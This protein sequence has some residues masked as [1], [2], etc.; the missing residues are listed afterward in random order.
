MKTTST[1]DAKLK[2]KFR[3]I[4]K[5]AFPDYT[6]RKIYS[7]IQDAPLDVRSF[8]DEGSRKYFTFVNLKTMQTMPMPAQ[9][10]YDKQIGGAE[11]VIIPQ[12][13]VCVTHSIF[14]GHDCGCTIIWSNEGLLPSVQ[15][16]LLSAN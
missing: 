2:N 3:A 14:M 4:V 9:S 12:D 13:C 11:T 8:W 16:N 5:T 1:T 15:S 6:C 10:A 7:K